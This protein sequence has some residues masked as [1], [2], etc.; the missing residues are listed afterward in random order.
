MQKLQYKAVRILLSTSVLPLCA[1][2]IITIIFLESIAIDNAKRSL[3]HYLDMAQSI[4]ED[5]YDNLRYIV[6]DEN[7]RISTLLENNQQDL[8]ITELKKIVEKNKLDFFI[9]TDSQGRVTGSINNPQV[10]GEDLSNNFLVQRALKGETSVSTEILTEQE[11]ERLG[12]IQEARIPGVEKTQGLVIQAV[13][14]IINREERI[15]GTMSAGYLLNNN[16]RILVD[17]IKRT[18]GLV[19]TIFLGDLRVSSNVLPKRDRYYAAVGSKLD[20]AGVKQVLQR[21]QKHISRVRVL[22]QWYIAGY[23]PLYNGN[24]NIIGALG[25]GM[26]EAAIFVLRN[27]LMRIFIIAVLLSIILALVIGFLMGGRIVKSIEKLRQGIAAVNKGDFEQR[28]ELHS[29]DE[30]EE[31][32]DFFNQMTVQIKTARQQLEGYTKDLENKVIQRTAQ[33]EAVHKV[34]LENEKM[35]AMGKMALVLSHEL[36]NIFAGIQTSTYYLRGKIVKDHPELAKSFKDLEYEVNYA[37][38]ILENVLRFSRPRKLILVDLDINL[39][40]EEILSTFSFQKMFKDN[41][42]E[43]IRDLDSG[44]PSIKADGIQIKEVILNIIIN[45]VQ[46]MPNGGRLT[47][48]TKKDAGFIRIELIDTGVGIPKEVLE[49]LFAPF[50]TTKNRGLGLGLCISKEIV[51]A[52]KGRIEVETQLNKGSKFIISLPLRNII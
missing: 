7:R 31:L 50:F 44:L 40:I 12:L 38:G 51:E 27:K 3:G 45:A 4:V 46:A 8:L 37:N 36:K 52:H 43:I 30:I 23:M 39:I 48:V 9:T 28:V 11:L 17:E 34:L 13:L 24:K 10:Q 29:K 15:I 41:N 49:N 2:A 47:I 14:P 18:T 42:I 33:L 1:V 32:A 16:N 21:G 26:S 35:A 5:V 22:D 6:R 25:I 20:S 19:S